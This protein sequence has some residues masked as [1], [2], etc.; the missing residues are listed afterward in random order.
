MSSI[1][2]TTSTSL[3][4]S[5]TS[6]ERVQVSAFGSTENSFVVRTSPDSAIRAVS[7][8]RV[9]GS[10]WNWRAAELKVGARAIAPRNLSAASDESPVGASVH[11]VTRPAS[12]TAQRSRR[13]GATWTA[14]DGGT[15]R[16]HFLDVATPRGLHASI[17]SPDRWPES[18]VN[19]YV[20]CASPFP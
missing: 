1:S 10:A 16:V 17:C 7:R 14:N 18:G 19:A 11:P 3:P 8:M 15:D 5:S 4:G 12:R 6:R 2:T 20:H 9:I 13:E